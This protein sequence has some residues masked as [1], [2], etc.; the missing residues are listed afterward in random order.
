MKDLHTPVMAAVLSGCIVCIAAD[1][2]T[3]NLVY[4]DPAAVRSNP[5]MTH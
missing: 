5:I 4:A 3:S 1:G 2:L